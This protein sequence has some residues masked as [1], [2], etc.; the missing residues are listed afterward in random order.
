MGCNGIAS[1]AQSFNQCE[2]KDLVDN[3]TI[4]FPDAEPL[5]GD[6]CDMPYFIAGDNAFPLKT[7]LMKPYSTRGPDV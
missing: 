1:D 2:L 3:E 7:W 4:Q 6:D 5:P